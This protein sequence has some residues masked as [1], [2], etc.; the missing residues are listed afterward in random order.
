MET[1]LK[2]KGAIKPRHSGVDQSCGETRGN[3]DEADERDT[4]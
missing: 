2:R 3:A 1:N 4:H